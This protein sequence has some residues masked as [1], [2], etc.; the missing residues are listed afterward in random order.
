MKYNKMSSENF[1]ENLIQFDDIDD[2][3]EELI[4]NDKS[5]HFRIHPKTDYIFLEI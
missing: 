5:Y 2:I 1:N 4:T 3:V